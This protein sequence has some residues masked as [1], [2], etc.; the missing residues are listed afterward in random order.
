MALT[1]AEAYFKIADADKDGVIGGGEAVQ[2]F[3]KSG[4]PQDTLGQVGGGGGVAASAP[5]A[6]SPQPCMACALVS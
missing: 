4:L 5:A 3:L 2:F 6:P 1:Q